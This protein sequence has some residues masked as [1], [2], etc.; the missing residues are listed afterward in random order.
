M[1]WLV[2]TAALLLTLAPSSSQERPS[3][4]QE[5]DPYL[6]VTIQVVPRL[7][8]IRF[9]L[10]GRTLTTD[11]NGL[12]FTRLRRPG[13]HNLAAPDL[14]R[15]EPGVRV[16][17]AHWAD[18]DFPSV[19]KLSVTTF[20][21]LEAG[22]DVSYSTP[23]NFASRA[24]DPIAAE[25]IDSVTIID[26]R[27]T[28]YSLASDG[29]QWLPG[30]RALASGGE[31]RSE[32][33]SYT[34]EAV[35]AGGRDRLAPGQPRFHPSPGQSWNIVLDSSPTDGRAEG[36]GVEPAGARDPRATNHVVFEVS[37]AL[38]GFPTGSAVSIESPDGR[39]QR[40]E[41]GPSA[42]FSLEEAGA[43]DFQATA[44]GPGISFAQ[45]FDP[46]RVERVRL[47]VITYL[48][49]AIGLLTLVLVAAGVMALARRIG[50]PRPQRGSPIGRPRPWFSSTR[51]RALAAPGTGTGT[52]E[53]ADRQDTPTVSEP[54]AVPSAQPAPEPAPSLA[55]TSEPAPAADLDMP[56]D[57]LAP[58]P[59]EAR[60]RAI[61]L[62]AEAEAA[63]AE[64]RDRAREI[65][66]E[67]E[68]S[69]TEARKRAREIM[70]RA[71][72]E[73][74][75]QTI[76]LKAQAEVA[77][78]DAR[79]Q[80]VEIMGEA[81]SDARGLREMAEREAAELLRHALRRRNEIEDAG[82]RPGGSPRSV[83]SLEE[84]GLEDPSEPP[85]QPRPGVTIKISD[86]SLLEDQVEAAPSRSGSHRH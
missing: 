33:I 14:Q 13:S 61:E 55:S 50:S 48:D 12:A 77:V 70:Q 27:D 38:F 51:D 72:E 9:L 46:S 7:E 53:G 68:N 78:A 40:H 23:V 19:R 10:D 37:D 52:A 65:V 47:S 31:I 59:A 58:A 6:P 75:R 11:H 32:E 84:T 20:T 73:A 80:A 17:F 45:R 60:S 18:G 83:T 8:G 81:A 28:G 42:R 3:A 66:A 39:S 34:L 16:H 29:P 86:V 35:V 25:D 41:L 22:F 49:I 43:G 26:D 54:T 21:T 82:G 62:A 30:S 76:E 67:A 36:A 69:L 63:L 71:V 85:V 64:A 44:L 15:I 4:G 5:V 57:P 56:S 24:G 1:T 74:H 2:V 79:E